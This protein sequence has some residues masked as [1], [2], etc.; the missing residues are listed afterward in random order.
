MKIY[1]K[2]L[3]QPKPT[4]IM[5]TVVSEY[6]NCLYLLYLRSSKIYD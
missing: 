1:L 4:N 5:C 2:Y 3:A 6:F